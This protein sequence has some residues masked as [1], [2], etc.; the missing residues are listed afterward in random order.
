MKTIILVLI[1][2]LVLIPTYAHAMPTTKDLSPSKYGYYYGLLDGKDNARDATS[3]CSPY[4]STATN[5]ECSHG[6]DLGFKKGCESYHSP[7]DPDPEYG[8]CRS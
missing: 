1:P 3:A 5:N 2:L 6:Y 4:N 8:Q 7:P